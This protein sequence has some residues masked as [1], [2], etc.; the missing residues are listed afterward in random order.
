M[1][2]CPKDCMSCSNSSVTD[3]DEL[4][5]IVHKKIVNDEDICD[6]YN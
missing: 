4:F 1:K 2:E 6:E 3:E 5:C